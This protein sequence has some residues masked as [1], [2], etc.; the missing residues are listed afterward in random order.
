MSTKIY[1]G[2]RLE[3]GPEA[4]FASVMDL[5]STYRSYMRETVETWMLD[6]QVRTAVREHVI[7]ALEDAGLV[8]A[9]PGKKVRTHKS[10]PW[11][12][13]YGLLK[14]SNTAASGEEFTFTVH[15]DPKTPEYI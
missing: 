7:E 10:S 5:I 6:K 12:S 11:V 15:Q 1:N 3:V 9:K 4:N 13:A 14:E 2:Y 8:K